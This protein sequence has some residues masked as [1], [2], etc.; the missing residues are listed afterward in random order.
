MCFDT[1]NYIYL[2]TYKCKYSNSIKKIKKI[3]SSC[4]VVAVVNAL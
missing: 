1:L 3:K 4:T 2:F